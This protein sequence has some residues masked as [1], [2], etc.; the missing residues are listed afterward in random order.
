MTPG[1]YGLAGVYTLGQGPKSRLLPKRFTFQ[2]LPTPTTKHHPSWQEDPWLHPVAN[3]LYRGM[4]CF[5]REGSFT[6]ASLLVFH[7]S[8]RNIPRILLSMARLLVQRIALLESLKMAGRIPGYIGSFFGDTSLGHLFQCPK[9]P[10]D[11]LLGGMALATGGG[12]LRPQAADPGAVEAAAPRGTRAL[13]GEL[14]G[15]QFGAGN[16]RG[17]R[18]FGDAN[19]KQSTDELLPFGEMDICYSPLFLSKGIDHYWIFFQGS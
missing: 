13:R 1:N 9:T 4:Y 12:S 19:R 17:C 15:A 8:R 7:S 5:W 11:F 14:Q 2:Q 6:S 3:P 10:L 18:R 16:A